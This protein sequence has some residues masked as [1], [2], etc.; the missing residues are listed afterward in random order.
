MADF[1]S[2][3]LY[4]ISESGNK[5]GAR[6]PYIE[7]RFHR[8][9]QCALILDT[10]CDYLAHNITKYAIVLSIEVNYRRAT[11]MIVAAIPGTVVSPKI[12]KHNLV[13]TMT[14]TLAIVVDRPP[15]DQG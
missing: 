7:E 12:C 14:M 8:V 4:L 15:E 2:K 9:Y 1:D 3:W 11:Q 10:E 6:V 5:Y 13:N